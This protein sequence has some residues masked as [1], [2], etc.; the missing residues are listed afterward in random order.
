MTQSQFAIRHGVCSDVADVIR[1]VACVLG[2]L[3]E[4]V[5]QGD[6]ERGLGVDF[7]GVV[8]SEALEASRQQGYVHVTRDAVVACTESVKSITC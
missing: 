3:K 7:D 2:K 6:A 8:S 4:L 5:R 1:V